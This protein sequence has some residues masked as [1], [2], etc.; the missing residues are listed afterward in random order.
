MFFSLTCSEGRQRERGDGGER[1]TEAKWKK[2]KSDLDHHRLCGMEKEGERER[3]K[4]CFNL[5]ALSSTH[6]L[7]NT[8]N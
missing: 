3:E 4:Y 2:N 8:K 1:R 5:I 7:L 6:I